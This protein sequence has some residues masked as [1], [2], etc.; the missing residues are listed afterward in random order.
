MESSASHFKT[1]RLCI[2]SFAPLFIQSTVVWIHLNALLDF[3]YQCY[4]RANVNRSNWM[5]IQ[6]SYPNQGILWQQTQ[7]NVNCGGVW[8]SYMTSSKSMVV[9][10]GVFTNGSNFSKRK[11]EKRS[12]VVISSVTPTK[13][14]IQRMRSVRTVQQQRQ[15]WHTSMSSWRNPEQLARG[16]W[17]LNGYQ[18]YVNRSFPRLAWQPA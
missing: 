2:H 13:A 6:T 14:A 10:K 18:L 7:V 4:R 16:S 15:L 8:T 11:L 5:R 3:M 9:N 1:R 17:F 12:F